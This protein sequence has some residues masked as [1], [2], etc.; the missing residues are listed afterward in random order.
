MYLILILEYLSAFIFF[1]L[2]ELMIAL[3]LFNILVAIIIDNFEKVCIHVYVVSG[4]VVTEFRSR[5]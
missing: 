2:L 4:R 3:I 1:I 5:L